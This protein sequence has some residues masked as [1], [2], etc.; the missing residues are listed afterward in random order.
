[1]VKKKPQ[2][3]AARKSAARRATKVAGAT[4]KA[5]SSG[6]S[7]A[8]GIARAMTA[9]TPAKKPAARPRAAAP[10]ASAVPALEQGARAP[11]FSLPRDGGKTISLG[12]FAGTKLVIYFYPRADTP[13]CTRESMDFTRLSGEFAAAHAKVIGVSADA[14]KAQDAFR[15]KYSLLTPLVSDEAKGMIKAYGAWGKKSMYGKTFEGVIR[16]TV[17]VGADGR[18]ARIWRNVR[19]DGHADEVLAAVRG[20]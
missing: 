4:A 17:L 7:T 16:T 8:A 2:K 15:D 13:G 19:V 10:A 9:K 6:R 5:R 14:P 20:I 11:S 12:D 18:V 1:M 3:S